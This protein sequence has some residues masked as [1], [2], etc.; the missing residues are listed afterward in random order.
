MVFYNIFLFNLD[1]HI[2]NELSVNSE[3][4]CCFFGGE[5]KHIKLVQC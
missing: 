5:V 1:L 3:R 2:N 4:C